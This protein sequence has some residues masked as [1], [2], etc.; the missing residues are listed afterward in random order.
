MR[1]YRE[2]YPEKAVLYS[3]EGYDEFGWAVFIGGGSL[4]NIP[5]TDARFLAAAAGMRPVD[6]NAGWALGDGHGGY[7]IY[8]FSPVSVDLPAGSYR[9]HRI[10][11]GDGS[12]T[13]L[14]KIKGGK[15]V[16]LTGSEKGAAVFWIEK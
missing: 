12:M 14:E 13:S 11:P 3:A 1:E 6:V 2:R 9:V 8:S 15:T 7:I 5:V 4:A 16:T 10:R